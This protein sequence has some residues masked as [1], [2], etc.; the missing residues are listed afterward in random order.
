MI[1]FDHVFLYA[2]D[3]KQ[4]SAFLAQILGMPPALPSG[5]DGDIYRLEIEAAGAIQYHP[6]DGKIPTHHIAF[7]VDPVTFDAA[8]RCIGDLGIAYG[9]DPEETKN[10]NRTTISG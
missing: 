3:A 5:P 7:R 1:Q 4:S 6:H 8:V 10:L 9:N 2:K